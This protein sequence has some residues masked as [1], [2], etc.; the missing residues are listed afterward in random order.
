MTQQMSRIVRGQVLGLSR[1]CRGDN[2]SVFGLDRVGSA[3]DLDLGWIDHSWF[4]D[5]VEEIEEGKSARCLPQQVALGLLDH[6]VGEEE[7]EAPLESLDEQLSRWPM[8]RERGGKEDARVD[9][10]SPTRARRRYHRSL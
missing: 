3:A 5:L 8:L 1:D 4:K 7:S 2:R 9:E 10:N 6:E